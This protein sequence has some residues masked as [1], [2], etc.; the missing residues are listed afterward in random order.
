[1]ILITDTQY[2]ASVIAYKYLIKS[3]YIKIEQYERWQKMSFRN[4]CIVAGANGLLNLSVPVEGGRHSDKLIREIKID[5]TRD[6][7]LNHWRTIVS[8]Y[9]RSPWFE[10]YRD[11]LFLFYHT[12]YELL[13]NWNLDILSWT[14][15]KLGGEPEISFTSSWQKEYPSNEYLD[16]RN[17][18]LPRNYISFVEDC[19]RYRQVFEDRIGFNPNLSI[20]DILF[21]E[22]PNAIHLLKK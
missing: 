22:G 19:P 21:C 10:F 16:L 12:H 17:R 14:L 6:W 3:N 18:I 7:Q 1:M 15:K 8:A 4:R 2:F 13:W 9:N 20:M 11:E 5:N